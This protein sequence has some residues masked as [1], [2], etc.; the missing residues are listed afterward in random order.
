MIAHVCGLNSFC[1]LKPLILIE[2]D[3]M[4]LLYKNEAKIFRVPAVWCAGD[5]I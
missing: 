1:L 4:P 2:M 5:F 3:D